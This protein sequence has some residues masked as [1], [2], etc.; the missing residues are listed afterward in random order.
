MKKWSKKFLAAGSVGLQT[1]QNTIS[2]AA[3]AEKKIKFP[4]GLW[5]E[6]SEAAEEFSHY[7]AET[8]FAMGLA[9]GWAEHE[10]S[11]K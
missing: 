10:E 6:L 3:K 11:V 7:P 4:Q 8:A 5:L 1:R 2:N 9:V